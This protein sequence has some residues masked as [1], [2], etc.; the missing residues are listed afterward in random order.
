MATQGELQTASTR[1][2]L[3]GLLGCGNIGNDA[4]MEAVIR[5]IRARHP[6]VTIDAMCLGAETV[7]QEYGIEAISLRWSVNYERA[8]FKAVA[9]AFKVLSRFVDLVRTAAW[10]RRHEVVIVPGMGV[11][12][13]SL[14][15]RPWHMPYSMFLV[16]LWGR[17]FGIRTALVS[18]G[19]GRVEGRLNRLLL[20]AVARL[21]FYRSY[22]DVRSREVMRQRGLDVTHDR[23]YPDLAFNLP[24]MSSDPGDLGIV[25]VGIM[26]YRGSNADRA[27]ADEVYAVYIDAMKHFVRWLVSEGRKVRLIIGDTNN[28]DEWALQEL[29]EDVRI[30]L[31]DIDA[32][33]VV[34]APVASFA[35][36]MRAIAPAG[37]VVATRFHNV[38]CALRLSKPTIALGYGPKFG[39]LMADMGV[40]EFCQDA[41]TLSAHELIGLFCELEQRQA[42]V[43]HRLRARNDI[44]EQ[45]LD[46]Q[47]KALSAVLFGMN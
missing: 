21:A 11:L 9:P 29:L 14:P 19:A 1:V 18:V 44:Y 46:D 41:R 6:G 32:E 8:V 45:L 24:I 47:F 17:I 22:R 12:E 13:T 5:Y 39:A 40:P 42:E 3:F 15:T 43:R 30:Y 10:V 4:S 37:T 34:A 2:G 28:C 27:R 25:C 7:R 20:D 36:V 31:P 26:D 23:V 33:Q 35:D 16:L 38:V